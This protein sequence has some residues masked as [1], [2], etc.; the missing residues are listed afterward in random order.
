[1]PRSRRD[2]DLY[3]YR[4]EDIDAQ[5]EAAQRMKARREQELREIS[6]DFDGSIRRKLEEEG[7]SAKSSRQPAAGR[8]RRK[9]SM[10]ND[11]AD[12]VSSVVR[13][14]TRKGRGTHRE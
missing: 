14:W 6:E 12:V 4:P 11:L 8:R 2:R 9:R 3:K 1:M 10:A 5:R 13:V 7:A